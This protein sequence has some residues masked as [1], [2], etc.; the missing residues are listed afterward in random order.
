[1]CVILARAFHPRVSAL[2]LATFVAYAAWTVAL[3]R[4]AAGIR[5]RVKDADNAITGKAVDALLNY[6]TVALCGNAALEAR[7][8]DTALTAYQVRCAARVPLEAPSCTQL[9]RLLA[10]LP[11]ANSPS[12]LQRS[13]L[14]LDTAAAALNAGQAL[15]L[16]GGL[17]AVMV[18]AALGATP[19]AAAAAAVGRG[20]ISGSLISAGDLGMIQGLLLQLWSPLQF[21]VSAAPFHLE[22]S[23]LI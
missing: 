4:V 23:A 21:L 1:M 11:D 12:L 22:D 20:V 3:T 10:C 17:T 9:H 14:R 5:R 19:A 16:A 15:I 13:V 2:V 7:Q 6:E 8:Y 18:A